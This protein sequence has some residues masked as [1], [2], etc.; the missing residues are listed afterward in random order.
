MQI[1]IPA[2]C[3]ISSHISHIFDNHWWIRCHEGAGGGTRGDEKV[4]EREE[5]TCP[6]HVYV[7]SS[8]VILYTYWHQNC[9]KMLCPYDCLQVVYRSNFA[10]NCTHVMVEIGETPE[11]LDHAKLHVRERA[12]LMHPLCTVWP[13]NMGAEM[14]SER[15]CHVSNMVS[16]NFSGIHQGHASNNLKA[17]KGYYCASFLL[18]PTL[19]HI[20]MRSWAC[21]NMIR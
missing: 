17:V 11:S 14:K 9:S 19:D 2:A 3:P 6:S 10:G 13:V 7:F 16:E 21:P 4:K 5:R 20:I 12:R 1:G 8:C 18:D 15:S